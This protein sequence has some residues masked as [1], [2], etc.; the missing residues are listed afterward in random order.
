[1]SGKID[2][3]FDGRINGVARAGLFISLTKTGAEGFV[4][5]SSLYGDY[6]HHDKEH[7]LIEG[8]RSGLV[9]QL[10]DAVCVRLREANPISGGLI[11]ELLDEKLNEFQGRN[12]PGIKGRRPK[13]RKSK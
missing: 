9:F 3:E 8:E 12:K 2:Q 7:H 10:G 13:R 1:M 11:F 6:F 4:P 5:I